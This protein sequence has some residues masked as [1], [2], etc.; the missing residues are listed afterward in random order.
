MEA[1]K[2]HLCQVA[3][4]GP[5]SSNALPLS[6]SSGSIPTTESLVYLPRE[7]R[8]PLFNGR[9]GLSLRE[10]V[11]EVEVS[12]CAHHLSSVDRAFFVYDHLE[13]EAKEEIKYRS[14]E[15]REDP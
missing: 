10:W 12:V 14:R 3:V 4:V 11:E 5:S 13:G 15:E 1:D 7:R 8:C 6:V 2:A 9:G